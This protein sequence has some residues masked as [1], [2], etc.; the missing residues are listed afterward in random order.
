MFFGRIVS[1]VMAHAAVVGVFAEFW[2]LSE[3]AFWILVGALLL[4]LAVHRKG[5]GWILMLIIVLLL[6]AILGVFVE[7]PIVS[8]Y[9][10]W[11]LAANYLILVAGTRG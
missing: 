4:W 10:F 11:V 3:Y 5:R 6:V 2:I 7:I 9:A 1:L 8:Q